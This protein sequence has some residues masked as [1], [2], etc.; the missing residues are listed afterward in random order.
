M[1]H[2]P[3]QTVKW[4]EG[5]SFYNSFF[6]YL[7]RWTQLYSTDHLPIISCHFASK[8]PA[9]WAPAPRLP[10][11]SRDKCGR[12]A[13]PVERFTE[14][15]QLISC[16]LCESEQSFFSLVWN[17]LDIIDII[18]YIL[19]LSI[20]AYDHHCAVV[21]LFP[22]ISQ[23]MSIVRTSVHAASETSEVWSFEL[24][25]IGTGLGDIAGYTLWLWLT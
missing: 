10:R 18:Y 13:G 19:I 15:P 24:Q 23:D 14:H 8:T 2:F 6:Q 3:L 20:F 11:P 5:N 17:M 22:V 25:E 12:R 4:P 9:I 7:R 1:F 16:D 21:F